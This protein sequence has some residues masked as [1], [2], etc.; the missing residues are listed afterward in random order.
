MKIQAF[1]ASLALVSLAACSGGGGGS[2]VPSVYSPVGT[3]TGTVTDSTGTNGRMDLRVDPS[4]SGELIVGFANQPSLDLTF[5]STYG[6]INDSDYN[7]SGQFIIGGI[8]TACPFTLHGTM[9]SASELDG[10]ITAGDGSAACNGSRA[11]DTFRV[12]RTGLTPQSFTRQHTST[13]LF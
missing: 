13:P 1:F 10:T 2:S 5:S 12:T 7:V 9:Q 4:G 8:A 6:H 3:F 11:N